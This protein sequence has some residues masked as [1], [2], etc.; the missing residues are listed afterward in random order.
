MKSTRYRIALTGILSLWFL[1]SLWASA[2]HVFSAG[3]DKPPFALLGFAVIPVVLFIAWSQISQSFRSFV[4]S[5]DPRTLTFLQSWRVV[6]F[7]FVAL[8]MYKILPSA[9]GLGAGYGDV[10]IGL[11]APFVALKMALPAYRN[12]FVL[13]Q[14]LGITDL[15][16]AVGLGVASR[17]SHPSTFAMSVLP[18]SIV[19][20][21][22]VPVVLMLH[23]VCIAQAR[24]WRT[25]SEAQLQTRAQASIA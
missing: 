1:A 18:L 19:P 4:L 3:P 10:F 14:L 22:A 9:F 2:N 8:E 16:M 5:L 21:F 6:G 20:T 24:H 7:G 11:T 25:S 17:T 13:W 23:L 12:R 15:A